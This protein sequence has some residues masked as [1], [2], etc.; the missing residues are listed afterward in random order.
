ME[1]PKSDS[2]FALLWLLF[3]VVGLKSAFQARDGSGVAG[4]SPCL[5]GQVGRVSV[6][7][8]ALKSLAWLPQVL[9]LLYVILG[10][11]S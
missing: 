11:A 6:P 4:L 10:R 5:G 1:N 2:A 8:G 9:G 3:S 7:S